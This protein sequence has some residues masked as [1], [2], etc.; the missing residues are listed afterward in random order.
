LKL[1]L[2]ALYLII[3]CL[4]AAAFGFSISTKEDLRTSIVFA[5]HSTFACYL[6]LFSYFAIRQT[7]THDHWRTLTHV[8]SLSCIEVIALTINSLLPYDN[9][10]PTFSSSALKGLWFSAFA[11]HGIALL[12][13][14]NIPGGP[15]LH[16]DPANLYSVKVIDTMTNDDQANVAGITGKCLVKF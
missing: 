13:V 3:L 1:L 15:V 5:F 16:C 14:I 8:S 4:Y 6:L 12:I 10:G 2:A 9:R 7:D 11:L